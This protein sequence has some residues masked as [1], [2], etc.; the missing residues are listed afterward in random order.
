MTVPSSNVTASAA[1]S[2][3][4]GKY[5]SSRLATSLSAV[6][7]AARSRREPR[8]KCHGKYLH[9]VMSLR[10]RPLGCGAL[11]HLANS[12]S[13]KARACLFLRIDWETGT[14]GRESEVGAARPRKLTMCGRPADPLC[15]GVA[16]IA[17]LALQRSKG[18][19]L[20]I[21]E[22]GQGLC[23][24]PVWWLGGWVTGAPG[25]RGKWGGLGMSHFYRRR[26]ARS[27]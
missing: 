24:R 27:P 1:E 16:R 2:C 12:R 3:G 13:R 14:Q 6:T 10:K 22:R 18:N 26:H 5:A 19:M 9:V 15:A 23:A 21:A 4:D 8:N 17:L 25:E 7:L 20:P 11:Y